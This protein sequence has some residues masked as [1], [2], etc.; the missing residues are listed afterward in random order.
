MIRAVTSTLETFK[1]IVLSTE[2]GLTIVVADR[3]PE[4]TKKETRNRRGKSSLVA[5]VD[6]LLGAEDFFAEEPRLLEEEFALELSTRLG[7][8]LISRAPRAQRSS[9]Y[10]DSERVPPELS[11]EFDDET[12]RKVASL[13]SWRAFLGHAFF[14]LP[15]TRQD[16][17]KSPNAPTYRN[18]MSYFLRREPGGF[19]YPDKHTD[20]QQEV[21]RQV[22]ISFF[23]E[24]EW[25]IAQAL[26]TVRSE[27]RRLRQLKIEQQELN[28]AD[29]R[30]ELA[31][32]ERE[33]HDQQKFLRDFR[34]VPQFRQ[35]EKEASKLA[36]QIREL[37]DQDTV[38][39]EL[40]D[41]LQRALT[42]EAPPSLDDVERLY[43]EA[44]VLLGDQVR[45]R[46]DE[47]REFHASVI[48]NRRL[49]LETEIAKAEARIRANEVKKVQRESRRAEILQILRSG[50]ALEQHANLQAEVARLEHHVTRLKELAGKT[51]EYRRREADLKIERE[52]LRK[53][54]R[55]EL[56][57]R[58]ETIRQAIL[59]YESVSSQLYG[60]AGRLTIDDTLNGPKLE[61]PIQGERSKGINSMRIFCFDMTLVRLLSRRG[62]GPRFLIHDSH[63]FDGVDER[64]VAT[65]LAVGA[66]TAAAAKWQYIVTMNSDEVP[67][68]EL[69]PEG[70]DVEKHIHPVRLTDAPGGGLFGFDF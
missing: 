50:G 59:D 57:E 35:L 3:R 16:D 23:L 39:R 15:I 12:G 28:P 49:Y 1:D 25:R 19:K 69:Y 38:D 60:D 42:V 2:P 45:Q 58:E 32:K 7:D 43:G 29:V 14:G 30:T 67:P 63:L 31:I 33:L 46:L 70:F 52:N 8:L 20:E 47:V 18:L 66:A 53:R 6:Y 54:L 41:E 64:Q 17:W 27:E 5:L 34:V 65:A 56:D 48:R 37:S 40:V 62:F 9:I 55:S 36:R 4:S 13:N 61:F 51:S 22:A 68:K 11:Y 26:E 21:A 10:I 24:F 44:Q